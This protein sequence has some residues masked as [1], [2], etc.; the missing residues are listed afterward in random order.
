MNNKPIS[1][2]HW[3]PQDDYDKAVGQ[4][5]LQ[6]GSVLRMFDIYGLGIYIPPAIESITKLTEDFGLRVRGVD[7]P[8]SL[9]LVERGEKKQ[10][11]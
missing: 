6:I 1:G 9:D 8:I 4:L 7:H 10:S 3:L 11:G 5:R 2:V